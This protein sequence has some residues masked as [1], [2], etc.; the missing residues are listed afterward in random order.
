[1][2]KFFSYVVTVELIQFCHISNLD[3]NDKSDSMDESI[4]IH[5]YHVH[6]TQLVSLEYMLCTRIL[7]HGQIKK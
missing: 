5:S 7:C 4:S 1:M 2:L 6:L 3:S